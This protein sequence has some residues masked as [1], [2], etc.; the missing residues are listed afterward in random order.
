MSITRP[1]QSGTRELAQLVIDR[2]I[3]LSAIP[4]PPCR[5]Q[6]RAQVAGL[7]ALAATVA[8][9]DGQEW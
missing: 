7:A 1:G 5:E 9:L 8:R 4:A 2:T 3:V 6:Q